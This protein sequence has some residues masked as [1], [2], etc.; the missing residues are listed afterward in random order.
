[1]AA[2]S[3]KFDNKFDLF[4]DNLYVPLAIV[5]STKFHVPV[6]FVM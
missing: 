4:T 1:M 5:L 3:L 2:K 6:A